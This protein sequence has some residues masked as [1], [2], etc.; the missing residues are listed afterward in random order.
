MA[1]TNLS[2]K[3]NQTHREQTC[4]CQAGPGGGLL[5]H[6]VILFLVFWGTSI[7]FS[8]IVALTYI[9]TNSVE[10]SLFSTP[11]PAFADFLMMAILIGV[12]CYLI[13]VL[14][15]LSLIISDVEH[16]FICLLT[17]RMSSLEKYL[18]RSSAYFSLGLFGF[19]CWAGWVVCMYILSP[20]WLHH[21]QRF[22]FP[23]LWVVFLVF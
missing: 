16:L 22:F 10:G 4:G 17:I 13:E 8:I 14:I 3:Q 19:S 6:M 7:L 2:P 23:I 15:C 12:K 5:D 21:S 20:C 9:H 1:Q 11:S 18:F